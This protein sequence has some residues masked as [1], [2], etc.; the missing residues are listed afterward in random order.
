MRVGLGRG[1]P[2]TG[3]SFSSNSMLFFLQGPRSPLSCGGSRHRAAAAQAGDY[4]VRVMPPRLC[5][6]GCDLCLNLRE[7]RKEVHSFS[8]TSSPPRCG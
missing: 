3:T 5:P 8:T 1:I 4:G 2:V 6:T 7:D